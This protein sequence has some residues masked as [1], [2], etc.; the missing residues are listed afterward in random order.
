MQKKESVV[1]KKGRISQVER[2]CKK[3]KWKNHYLNLAKGFM[4]STTHI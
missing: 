3:P 2:F 1:G 4:L